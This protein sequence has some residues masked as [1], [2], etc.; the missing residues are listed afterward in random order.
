M[1]RMFLKI[2]AIALLMLPVAYAQSLGDVARENREK[3][4][5]DA[6]T[7]PAKVITNKDLPK[8]EAASQEPAETDSASEKSKEHPSTDQRT[9]EQRSDDQR[10]AEQRASHRAVQRSMQQRLAEQRVAGQWKRQILAQENRVSGLQSRVDQ[11]KASI[12]ATYGSTQYEAPYSRLQARQ[13]QR[14]AQLQQ[15]L[16][17]QKMKLADMQESARRAGMHTVVYDP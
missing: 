16:D 3:K 4:A 5:E 15:Q 8:D 12:H 7:A 1:Q 13:L 10:S 9:A 17:E 6:S 14:V 11:M 2:L